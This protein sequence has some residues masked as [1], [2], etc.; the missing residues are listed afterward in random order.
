MDVATVFIILLM[1]Y[2]L[3]GIV[4]IV[5][6]AIVEEWCCRNRIPEFF[7]HYRILPGTELEEITETENV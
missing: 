7:Q 1:V 2:Y 6:T 4:V 3:F 5:Y